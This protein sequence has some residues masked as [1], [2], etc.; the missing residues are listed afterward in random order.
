MSEL[1][2]IILDKAINAA[3]N[4]DQN[5]I[6]NLYGISLIMIQ[7]GRPKFVRW[8][9]RQHGAMI[10]DNILHLPLDAKDN[11]QMRHAAALEVFKQAGVVCFRHITQIT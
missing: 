2:Q 4:A 9:K 5:I 8:L 11:L 7:D 10:T 3:N 6:E 1:Y